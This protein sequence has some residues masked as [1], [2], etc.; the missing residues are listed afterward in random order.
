M[1]SI[2]TL[3]VF[4]AFGLSLLHSESACAEMPPETTLSTYGPFIGQIATANNSEAGRE[5][6][7]LASTAT[8]SIRTIT[9]PPLTDLASATVISKTEVGQ[10]S[11][12]AGG[13][14]AGTSAA[15]LESCPSSTQTMTSPMEAIVQIQ[16]GDVVGTVTVILTRPDPAMGPTCITSSTQPIA[17]TTAVKEELHKTMPK[18]TTA[19]P[20]LSNSS[21]SG[22]TP[23][24]NWT[25]GHTTSNVSLI[26]SRSPPGTAL[27]VF[28]GDGT[29]H[30]QV[31][32]YGVLLFLA[33][34]IAVVSL[35]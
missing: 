7:P 15:A 3:P 25:A 13:D 16:L 33:F 29:M 21:Y 11:V 2:T 27:R 34:Q 10:P 24:T 22:F 20:T 32:R 18:G 17:E 23:G 14:A 30:R 35:L 26:R 6:C 12:P 5:A 19:V 1:K 31:H 8:S 28:T 4:F 9:D